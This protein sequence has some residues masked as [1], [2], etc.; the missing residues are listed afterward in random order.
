[1]RE[2]KLALVAASLVLLGELA[3]TTWFV[4]YHDPGIDNVSMANWNQPLP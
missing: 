2:I 4:L 3:L 1:M